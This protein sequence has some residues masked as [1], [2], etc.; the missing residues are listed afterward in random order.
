MV[1]EVLG[2]AVA[3]ESAGRGLRIAKRDW[4][5]FHIYCY[6]MV[7]CISILQACI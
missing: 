3:H 1:V 6:I 5:S 2:A 4:F 7:W